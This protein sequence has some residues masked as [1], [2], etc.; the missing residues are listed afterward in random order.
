MPRPLREYAASDWVRLRPLT[1]WMKTRRYHRIDQHYLS[2]PCEPGTTS[3]VLKRIR[4][5]QTI[6]TIAFNDVE[7]IRLQVNLVA[8]YIPHAVHLIAD[9]SSKPAASEAISAA[10]ADNGITYL[11]VPTNPWT[12][13]NA[14]RS[15]GFAMNWVWRHLIK[16]SKPN[17]FGFI[18][19]D[20]FPTAHTDPFQDL[21]GL[22]CYGDK[23]WAGNRWFLWAGYCFYDFQQIQSLPLDFG[24]DWFAGL[25]TGGA[26]WDVL[27]KDM[28]PT[29]LRER[30]IQPR[31]VWPEIDLR[32]AY[33]EWRDE[34][35]HEVGLDGRRDLRDAKR[36][37]LFQLLQPYAHQS[38]NLERQ[39]A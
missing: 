29:K 39:V 37:V 9:N 31:Q 17:Q 4:D 35:V 7:A 27:Y 30:V 38:T 25:D 8:K 28:M 5:R 10:C 36:T 15:H 12:G 13:R 23:R 21:A 1:H 20:L 26:N 6:I 3:S 22:P 2:Q 16:P 34:W 32:D 18:D 14:S 33:F 24:L 11:R 19:H